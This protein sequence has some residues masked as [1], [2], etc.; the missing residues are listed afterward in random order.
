[1]FKSGNEK[2]LEFKGELD[3][4]LKSFS[5]KYSTCGNEKN[6]ISLLVGEI[7]TK[8]TTILNIVNQVLSETHAESDFFEDKNLQKDY[9][10]TI[11][12]FIPIS[13][14]INDC[15]KMICEKHQIPYV[16]IS[17]KSYMTIQRFINTFSSP[18]KV[19]EFESKFQNKNI[20]ID[21]FKFKFYKTMK[22][23]FIKL[24]LWVGI[25]LLLLSG[26]TVIF[27]ERI[28]E[29]DF[30]GIQLIFI[31]ALI[32]L[33][34][35]IVGSSLVEGNANIHWTLRKGLTIRAVSW[36]AIFLLIY[37]LNPASPGDVH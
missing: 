20:S 5:K 17:D 28:I 24:Q 19:K 36:V 25:P 11:E 31:K 13:L 2:I 9:I 3:F 26:I 8:H 29:K 34:I 37:F 4:E 1:M 27:G 33:S 16:R 6:C 15:L 12:N 14:N 18:E 22:A 7:A 30:N 21:G 35:S 32:S 10:A 23:K